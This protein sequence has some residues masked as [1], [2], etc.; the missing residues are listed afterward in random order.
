MV[1]NEQARNAVDV[2]ILAMF[3]EL[4]ADVERL[5]RDVDALKAQG[6]RRTYARYHDNAEAFH[7]LGS[8][9]DSVWRTTALCGLSPR[10]VW[11]SIEWRLRPGDRL[12]SGC[13]HAAHEN[14]A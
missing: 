3:D 10:E 13:R 11:R 12:C 5:R 9:G 7:I 14:E 1:S 4:I 2:A 6:T 8:I